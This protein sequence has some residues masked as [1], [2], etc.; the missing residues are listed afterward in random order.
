[1]SASV[2]T[3]PSRAAL[4][5]FH[6]NEHLPDYQRKIIQLRKI[7]PDFQRKTIQLR[8]IANREIVRSSYSRTV[9]T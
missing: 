4:Y 1:M 5:Y 6:V 2:I 8:E 9:I 3:K 7:V